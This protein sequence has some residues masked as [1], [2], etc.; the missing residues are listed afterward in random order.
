VLAYRRAR[1]LHLEG[2]GLAVL[3]QALIVADVAAI[4]FSADP[5]TG[6]RDQVVINATWGLGESLVAGTATPHGYVVA[7]VPHLAI[8]DRQVGDPGRMTVAGPSGTY[9]VRVPPHLRALPAL[10][11]AQ[12]AEL[13]RL[14]CQLEAALGYPVDLECA[15]RDGQLALLQCRP[16]TTLG[17]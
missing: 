15:Y 13:A 4:V 1:G 11:D 2:Q 7:R 5:R 14:A 10:T 9:E 3:V 12:I 6:R 8:V 16:I 17:A